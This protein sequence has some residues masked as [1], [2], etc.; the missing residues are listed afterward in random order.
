MTSS[1]K[2]ITYI[3]AAVFLAVF[4][5]LSTNAGGG[6][7]FASAA[8]AYSSVLD[9]LKT[10]SEFNVEDYPAGGGKYKIEIIQIAES[11]S[12]ELL[13]YAYQPYGKL[14]ASS[15]S[16]SKAINDS[17]HPK[18]YPLKLLTYDGVFY[19]YRVE[20]F[21][22]EEDALRYYNVPTIWRKHDK[23]IDGNHTGGTT[24]NEIAYTVGK[25]WTATTVQ[26][27]ILYTLKE[28]ETVEILNPYSGFVRRSNG[29][30][31]TNNQSCDGHFIAFNTN[32][33][34]TRLISAD[35]TYR[36]QEYSKAIA[37]GIEY[38]E[39][40]AL[41]YRTV[42]HSEKAGNNVNGLFAD[43][44]NWDRISTTADFIADVNIQ[45]EQVKNDLKSRKWIINYLE[46][47]YEAPNGGDNIIA[48]LGGIGGIIYNAFD[49]LFSKMKGTLVKE[50]AVLRLEFE[51]DGK[52]YNL[53]AVSNV[54]T[55][56]ETPQ[57]EIGNAVD[58]FFK[59]ILAA[60]ARVPWWAWLIIF[61]V[62]VIIVIA[63]LSLFFPVLRVAL[64][65]IL[66]GLQVVFK[67]IWFVICLPFRGIA[68]LARRMQARRER[69]R[70]TSAATAKRRKKKKTSSNSLGTTTNDKSNTTRKAGTGSELK[71]KPEV[72]QAKE[73]TGNAKVQKREKSG[74]AGKR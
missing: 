47:E 66:K 62:L 21:E 55:G 20:E 50:V 46:T 16:I 36:T 12:A 48:V 45:D 23:Q 49:L 32:Y 51:V 14:E 59:N 41:Q 70:E 53:G 38:G 35:I 17:F 54:V 58:E 15:I 74:K 30:N 72:K 63:I 37:S 3:I 39:I 68:A 33:D 34:I 6:A 31:W 5:L 22:L 9:D 71:G 27:N 19:K 13:V 57:D 60:L 24:T 26:G 28:T 56:P 69:K 29:F 7:M 44:Y 8:S 43:K 61:G 10:D 40:S 73:R 4:G 52:H 18:K 11:T 42:N 67:G 25:L 65:E 2:K 64:Q 1:I